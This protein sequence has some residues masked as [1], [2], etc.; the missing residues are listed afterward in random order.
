MTKE[1]RKKLRGRII[2]AADE[3]T[4]DLTNRQ[5]IVTIGGHT[6][7]RRLIF[8]GGSQWS[9]CGRDW[10][11]IECGWGWV[12]DEK[13]HLTIPNLFGFDGHN[14]IEVQTGY[15]LLPGYDRHISI[16]GPE[17]G[18]LIDRVPNSILL[19]I[20]KGIAEACAAQKSAAAQE[21]AEAERLIVALTPT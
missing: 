5:S 18:T 11:S 20:A 4:E 15:Y 21:S 19:A 16:S 12:V 10:D 6:L 7:A 2:A 1:Q 3:M 9:G 8:A 14:I 13:H 17:D